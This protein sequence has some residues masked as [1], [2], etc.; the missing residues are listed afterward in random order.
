MP[1]DQ[2]AA[3]KLLGD[4]FVEITSALKRIKG[5][6]KQRLARDVISLFDLFRAVEESSNKSI[7]HLRA[8]QEEPTIGMKVHYIH[9]AGIALSALEDSCKRFIVWSYSHTTW[10]HLL[11]IFAPKSKAQYANL[12]ATDMGF[13]N[14]MKEQLSGELTKIREGLQAVKS[15]DPER[16]PRF[17][18]IEEALRKIE[19]VR[20]Q[21]RLAEKMTREFAKENLT[22]DDFF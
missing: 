3:L 17:K 1:I 19:Q 11:Q 4:L 22:V 18:E 13:E 21:A 14:Y 5:T 2:I 12:M 8:F 6:P 15:P 7:D 20:M 10:N 9:E 16:F